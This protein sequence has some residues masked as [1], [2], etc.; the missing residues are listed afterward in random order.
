MI[1]RIAEIIGGLY[2]VNQ[3]EKVNK[4]TQVDKAYKKCEAERI[5][6]VQKV[7]QINAL[8][9]QEK[10]SKTPQNY[11]QTVIVQDEHNGQK[12]ICTTSCHG[13]RQINIGEQENKEDIQLMNPAKIKATYFNDEI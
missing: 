11:F 8:N 5:A 4:G 9:E 12:M 2:Y 7:S 1:N 13:Y 6:K 3:A 10:N